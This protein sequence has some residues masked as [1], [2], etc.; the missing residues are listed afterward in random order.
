MSARLDNFFAPF[1]LTLTLSPG[2]REQPLAAFLKSESRRAEVSRGFAKTLET[3][4]PLPKGEG[5]GGG[6]GAFT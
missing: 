1:P 4:L 5:R 2:E 6:K 3:I